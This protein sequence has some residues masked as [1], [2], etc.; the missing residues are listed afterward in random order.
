M[1]TCAIQYVSDIH[2]EH[3]HNSKHHLIV[4]EI[5]D[6]HPHHQGSNYLVVAGDLTPNVHVAEKF[7]QALNGHY[8]HIF[9]IPGNHEFYTKFYSHTQIM[10]RLHAL[11]NQQLTVLQNQMVELPEIN[12]LGTTMWTPVLDAEF[13]EMNDS[14]MIL[15]GF[16][17]PVSSHMVKSWY[18]SAYNFLDTYL[19]LMRSIDT[20]FSYKR[21]KPYIVITHH[22][23]REIQDGHSAY[24]TACPELLQ[25][26][27]VWIHG[28]DHQAEDVYI[29]GCRVLSNPR[30]YPRELTRYNPGAHIII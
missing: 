8:T 4:E 5:I 6:N 25:R 24:F 18:M 29:N 12:I 2:L 27:N 23:P 7:F 26:A 22:V 28:H 10:A 16:R 14:K 1:D 19:P 17:Q 11:N 9:Y 15:R 30:G 20:R 3:I 21:V 13:Q